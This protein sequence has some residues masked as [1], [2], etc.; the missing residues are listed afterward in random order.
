MVKHSRRHSRV[1]RKRSHKRRHSRRASRRASRRCWMGGSPAAVNDNSM[2]APSAQSLA[3][4]ADYERLHTGQH[5]GGAF[6]LAAAAPVG[7]T[8]MLDSS[9]R[10]AARVDP[11]D[12]AVDQIQGMSD[13]SGGGR[14]KRKGSRKSLRRRKGRK[15]SRK[16]LRRRKSSRKSLRRRRQRGGAAL[17]PAD[18]GAPGMLLGAADEA[19]ALAGMNPEWKLAADPTSFAP[20]S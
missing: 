8:G 13:Q 18:Y 19:K 2:A 4:G 14:R 20:R 6:S 7:Y 1:S 12:Q 16:S 10:G 15:G 3:Q 5:G 17:Q 11:I 9:L